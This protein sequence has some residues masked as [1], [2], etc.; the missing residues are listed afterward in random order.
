M[1]DNFISYETM[2]ATQ[3]TA[4]WTYWMMF[5]TWFAGAATF[6]AVITSLYIANKKPTPKFDV[7]V[8]SGLIAPPEGAFTSVMIDVA[9]VGLTPIVLSSLAWE[10]AGKD[11][12]FN[13]FPSPYSDKL[14]KKIEHGESAKF[15]IEARNFNIYLLEFKKKIL[16]SGGDIDKLR[17]VVTLATRHKKR[18]KLAKDFHETLRSV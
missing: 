17:L 16:A 8:Y 3:D 1:N 9:N 13:T 18:F 12:I 15:I 6:M 2:I 5:A 14:P 7:S 10:F 11:I 4:K